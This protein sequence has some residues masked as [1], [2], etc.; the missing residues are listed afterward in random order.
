MHEK[1][2]F[3]FIDLIPGLNHIPEHITLSFLVMVLLGMCALAFGSRLNVLTHIVPSRHLSVVNLV[4]MACSHLFEF[5]A[6]I[7]DAAQA[8]EHFGFIAS[9]F[10]FIL[11]SNLIGLIPG[12]LP[13]AENL[14]TTLALGVVVFLYYNFVGF[15]TNG[16]VYAKHFLGPVIWISPLMLVIEL[17]SHLFRPIS[18]ALRLRGNIMGD[19]IILGVFSDLIPPFI[20]VP[21]LF[22]ALG[23]FVAF[24]Q[25]FV[26]S[27]MSMVYILLAQAHED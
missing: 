22:I 13:P 2:A 17:V 23:V 12:F 3:L 21:A 19:H 14:N 26:F 18:L 9:L 5:C 15:K 27:L 20:P 8:K 1:K 24:M 6:S 11:F 4:D 10:F 7:L 16:F 25:A